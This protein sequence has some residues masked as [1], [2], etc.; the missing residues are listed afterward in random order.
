[1]VRSLIVPISTAKTSDVTWTMRRCMAD[2][3]PRST[4]DPCA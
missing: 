1:V 4:V 2:P 3:S